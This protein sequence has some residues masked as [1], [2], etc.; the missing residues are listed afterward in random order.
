M[1]GVNC[2]III[3]LMRVVQQYTSKKASLL[4]PS[5]AYGN[6]KYLMLSKLF[7]AVFALGVLIFS[8]EF[9]QI[10]LM[11]VL[12]ASVSG[13]M[14][15]VTSFCGLYAIKSG[16]MALSS[17]FGTAGLIVPCIAGIF[18]FDEKMSLLQWVGI[19]MFLASSV[20]L[21]GATKKSNSSFSLK[22]VFLLVGSL[23]GNGITML[24]QT[25]F[26]RT[27]KN[28]SVSAFSFLSFII[29][30]IALLI[31]M[32]GCKIKS[33]E[34]SKTPL[35]KKLHLVIIVSAAALFVVN[36]LATI[37][38]GL[39]APAILF[40]FING[41]NTVIA[42]IMGAAI[43][44]EKLTVKSIIGITLGLLALITVKVFAPV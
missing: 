2:I 38:T 4:I 14:L 21:I 16:S 29:P 35:P 37:A 30:A 20:L 42:A 44:K 24:V 5:D 6:F 28:G 12:L 15:V 3:L 19:A 39:V 25:I 33:P 8:G 41:G 7:A 32:G 17:I 1:T 10:D 36:Q 26:S 40:T 9:K 31:V 23:V 22:T 11:T 43:F 18:L 13:I 27:V 34:T